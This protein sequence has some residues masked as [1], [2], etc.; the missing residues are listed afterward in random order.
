MAELVFKTDEREKALTELKKLLQGEK[1]PYLIKFEGSKG[2]F[3]IEASWDEE[4]MFVCVG[5]EICLEILKLITFNEF[6]FVATAI[7]DSKAMMVLD[8]VDFDSSR[9]VKRTSYNLTKYKENSD[10]VDVN[11]QLWIDASGGYTKRFMVGVE[12]KRQSKEGIKEKVK[13]IKRKKT[14]EEAKQEILEMLKKGQISF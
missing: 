14:W 8:S 11:L 6:S 5:K 9:L 7:L 10:D 1:R 3:T 12:I 4:D 2:S 13:I